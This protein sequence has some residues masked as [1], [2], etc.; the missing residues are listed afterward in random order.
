MLILH[1][2]NIPCPATIYPDLHAGEPRNPEYRVT[3]QFPL[4]SY[5]RYAVELLTEVPISPQLHHADQ[6]LHM[7]KAV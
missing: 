6:S 3:E 7:P 1:F 2:Q 4:N 5:R